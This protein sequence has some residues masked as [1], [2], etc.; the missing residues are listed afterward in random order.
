MEL[1]VIVLPIFVSFSTKATNEP[2]FFI[3]LQALKKAVAIVSQ[4]LIVKQ[5]QLFL[6]FTLIKLITNYEAAQNCYPD[7]QPRFSGS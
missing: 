7:Y 3:L 6:C 4:L 1:I 2:C 5:L